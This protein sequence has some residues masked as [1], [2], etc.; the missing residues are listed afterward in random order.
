[1]RGGVVLWISVRKREGGKRGGIG[2]LLGVG[3][4][5]GGLGGELRMGMGMGVAD[6]RE[7]WGGDMCQK[8]LMLVAGS[9]A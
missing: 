3:F 8:N 5:V 6:L 1:M 7:R 2:F 4:W 9:M